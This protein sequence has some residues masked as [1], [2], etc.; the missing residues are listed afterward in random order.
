MKLLCRIGAQLGAAAVLLTIPAMAQ[1]RDIVV[2]NY[3]STQGVTIVNASTGAVVHQISFSNGG[4]WLSSVTPDGKTAVVVNYDSDQLLT[5]DLS[6]YAV[7]SPVTLPGQYP[8]QLAIAPNGQKA[9]V[10]QYTGGL[11]EVNLSTHAAGALIPA[12]AE[13]YGVA[14]TPNGQTA[15]VSDYGNGSTDT[16]SVVPINLTTDTPGP[17]IPVPKATAGA[18]TPDG[19][20][21]WVETGQS[22]L[23]PINTSTNTA[24]S[25]ITL[26]SMIDAYGLA[27]SPDGKTAFAADYGND[28]GTTGQLDRVDLATRTVTATVADHN[29]PQFPTVMPDG[30]T[31]Y[32]SNWS[33]SGTLVPFSTSTLTMGTPIDAGPYGGQLGVVPNQ[34]PKATFTS[35]LSGATVHLNGSKSSDSDGT[36][37]KYEWNFG[38][39][40][41]ATTS[42]PKTSHR[43]AKAGKYKVTLT[44]VDNEGCSTNLVYTGQENSCTGSSLAR[45]SHTVKL[46]PV[47]KIGS[48]AKVEHGAAKVSLAC[49]GT[50]PCSGTLTVRHSGRKIGS[51]HFSIGAGGHATVS[52][53]LTSAGRS[54]LAKAGGKL[55][56]TATAT[57]HAGR[58]TRRTI[59]L[60]AASG[61]SFTG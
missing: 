35:K 59:T 6:T 10:A 32:T 22:T 53:R 56:A 44:V 58:T 57:V 19:S 27:I 4:P 51:V 61:P 9:Y 48:S 23:V 17:P 46:T 25:G 29:G 52:V 45:V 1:A 21:V 12:G 16:G 33:T 37:A 39:G 40:K 24:G 5:I 43:Y 54:A 15:Y 47:V 31:V 18:V 28:D 3:S 41:K 2:P 50:G 7:S 20:T 55:T 11:A 60:S 38:D 34:A 14:I 49:R 30:K 13:P 42:S 36:V 26:P 8:E